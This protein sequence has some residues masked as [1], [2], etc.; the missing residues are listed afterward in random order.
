[1]FGLLKSIA[2][3]KKE[4]EVVDNEN[5]ALDLQLRNNLHNKYLVSSINSKRM[6]N[7]EKGYNLVEQLDSLEEELKNSKRNC[8][9]L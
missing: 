5:R 8:I 2:S 3:K 9:D 7:V 4:I 1:M 6:S